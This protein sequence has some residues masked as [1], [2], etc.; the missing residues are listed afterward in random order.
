MVTTPLQEPDAQRLFVSR[1]RDRYRIVGEDVS[2]DVQVIGA[3]V[4]LG[5]GYSACR[6]EADCEAR[7]VGTVVALGPEDVYPV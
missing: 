3:I 6:V 2:G 4:L 5:R 7:V 1:S